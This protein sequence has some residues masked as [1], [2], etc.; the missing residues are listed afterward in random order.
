MNCSP[1]T[2][3]FFYP[4]LTAGTQIPTMATAAS[5]TPMAAG[6][7]RR[8]SQR[9][10]ALRQPPPRSAMT[11][12]E[13]QQAQ[14]MQSQ[15]N[16]NQYNDDSSEDEIPVPMKL[17]ALTKALLNDGR[18]ESAAQ[19][20]ERPPSPPRTRR[21]TSQLGASV[22]SM[23][24]RGRHR[25]S[26]GGQAPEG[27]TS[28][29]S[30][31]AREHGTSPPQ[32]K[33]VVRLSNTPQTLSQIQPSK[34]RSSSFSRSTQRHQQ[35]SRP[36]S[37]EKSADEKSEPPADINTPANGNRVV[38]ISTNSSGSRSKPGSAG[39]SSGRSF[40][41]SAVDR[42]AIE[43]DDYEHYEIPETV[44]RNTAAPAAYGSVSRHASAKGRQDDNGNPQSSMRIKRAGKIPGTFLSGPA[45]RGR[46]RQ[47]EEDAEGEGEMDQ[48]NPHQEQ[49]Q[50]QDQ[51][52]EDVPEVNYYADGIRDFNSGSPVSASASARALHRRQYSS[53]ESRPGSGRPS[54]RG[55][56][57]EPEPQRYAP[58][59][60]ERE[61]AE[62]EEI[63][64]RK[65]VLYHNI[66]ANIPST[67]EK[68]ND[69]RSA[70]K[71]PKSSFDDP[72]D[73]APARPMS[74]DPVFARPASPER[75]PLAPVANNTPQR[76]APP[77]P[78]KMSVMEAATSATGAAATSTSTKQRRNVLRVNG[79]TYTRLDCLGRGGSAKVYR[80]T[81]ENGQMFA[82]KRVALENADEMTIKGYKGEIDL[83][84]RLEGVDRVIN[85]FAYEM[86]LE[87]QVLSLV[88]NSFNCFIIIR[89]VDLLTHWQSCRSWKWES[90]T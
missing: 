48:Y 18:S 13:S 72:M 56:D 37:R 49:D 16:A 54:P 51:P 20:M 59:E 88:S 38:R 50:D 71:R 58:L 53:M 45:R 28:R 47:S 81:A 15:N 65:S 79:K 17:S 33:R 40:D 6:P 76:P 32:R 26:L 41:R 61:D 57:H 24:E 9:Q 30:S 11:R 7:V 10:Q 86:N 77:P 2:I 78:P 87:K 14:A 12:S 21:R 44:A 82:L 70:Y 23:S 22:S 83:L 19:A 27:K 4:R 42:S 60:R 3:F 89:N 25:A 68:E 35:S 31:P 43:M 62:E 46:R 36:A 85:L 90:E 63:P 69:I 55:F 73:K 29:T 52:M 39:V 64:Y 66:P 80:V 75:K 1:N 67:S 74:I 8:V 34:R 84:G 5:P